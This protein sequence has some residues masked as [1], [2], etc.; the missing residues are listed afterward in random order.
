MNRIY[1]EDTP[2]DINH[3]IS[4]TMLLGK[5]TTILTKYRSGYIGQSGYEIF[6]C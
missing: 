5:S 2:H 4:T 1:L 3:S 6:S